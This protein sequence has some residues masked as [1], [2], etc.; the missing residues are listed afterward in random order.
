[1]MVALVLMILYEDETLLVLS[2]GGPGPFGHGPRAAPQRS[3]ETVFL[4]GLTAPGRFS[5]G[6]PYEA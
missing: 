5:V 3:E 6:L 2:G 1:M 4:E